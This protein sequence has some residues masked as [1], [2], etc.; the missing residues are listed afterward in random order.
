MADDPSVCE[1]AADEVI[2]AGLSLLRQLE[3][4]PPIVQRGVLHS[5]IRISSPKEKVQS[6]YLPPVPIGPASGI[7]SNI[8][9]PSLTLTLHVYAVVPLF[10]ME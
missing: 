3:S 4:P 1:G 2:D 8:L 9:V 6:M 5:K 10:G 7:D